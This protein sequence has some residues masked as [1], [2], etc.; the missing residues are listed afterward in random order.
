MDDFQRLG[1]GDELLKGGQAKRQVELI[2][3]AVAH[4]GRG[5]PFPILTDSDQDRL[6][7]G[8]LV[9]LQADEPAFSH[10]GEQFCGPP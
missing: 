3:C 5:Y 2:L 9:G 1:I 8:P 6:V 10:K 7:A 4:S